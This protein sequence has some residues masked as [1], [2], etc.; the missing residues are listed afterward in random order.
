[1]STVRMVTLASLLIGGL[2]TAHAQ[3][4]PGFKPLSIPDLG[5]ECKTDTSLCRVTVRVEPDGNACKASVDVD[6]VTVKKKG[7][8]VIFELARIDMNDTAKYEFFGE[9]IEF[10]DL[11][12]KPKE[13]FMPLGLGANNTTAVWQTLAKPAKDLQYRPT[14]RRISPS[15]LDCPGAD[16]RI[17]NDGG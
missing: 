2:F 11:A 1:M 9:G 16:P 14:V 6:I 7:T 8:T 17:S 5:M 4:T 15:R 10:V 3:P 13:S 12:K